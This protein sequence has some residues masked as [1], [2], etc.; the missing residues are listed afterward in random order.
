M[1]K[2]V[3]FLCVIGVAA[4]MTSCLEGGNNYQDQGFV[5]IAVSNDVTPAV[6]YGRAFNGL[7]TARLIT[8]SHIQAGMITVPGTGQTVDFTPGSFFF[9]QYGW[10]E[11]NGHTSL[12]EN[13]YADNVNIF[14]L[15]EIQRTSLNFAPAPEGTPEEQFSSFA[16]RP[17]FFPDA[18]FWSD[19]WVIGFQY[20]GGEE[21]PL[22]RFYKRETS[23]T[24]PND[25]EIDVRISHIPQV[26]NPRQRDNF[27]A[28][29]MAGV[30]Q[31][32][33]QDSS[34]DVRVRF[35]YYLA[36]ISS[37]QEPRAM[38]TDWLP[39]RLVGTAQQ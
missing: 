12:G 33:Q 32:F 8:N 39:W 31:M 27:I 24:A 18:A 5:Y 6:R 7:F 21:M 19:N 3:L 38:S 16:E 17:A 36:P 29:N 23:E 15:A 30:R 25:I 13:R 1:K 4:M 10:E 35:N 20:I 22:V 26:S 37:G 11:A 2:V 28:F 14:G 9:F 34:R